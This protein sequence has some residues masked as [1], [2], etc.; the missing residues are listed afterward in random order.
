M[1]RAGGEAAASTSCRESH[2]EGGR[3]GRS[4]PARPCWQIPLD[5]QI[6]QHPPPYCARH[7]HAHA[8]PPQAQAQKVLSIFFRTLS[9]CYRACTT[10]SVSVVPSGPATR[11]VLVGGGPSGQ[12]SSAIAGRYP[13]DQAKI[14]SVSRCRMLSAQMLRC[15]EIVRTCVRACCS[16]WVATVYQLKWA[17]YNSTARTYPRPTIRIFNLRSSSGVR[18]G[19]PSPFSGLWWGH[20]EEEGGGL[21]EEEEEDANGGG[22]LAGRGAPEKKRWDA[23]EEPTTSPS[24]HSPTGATSSSPTRLHVKDDND[25]GANQTAPSRPC[26]APTVRTASPETVCQW[27]VWG[28]KDGREIG[29]FRSQIPPGNGARACVSFHLFL[30]SKFC[31]QERRKKERKY[32]VRSKYP[33]PAD[34]HRLVWTPGSAGTPHPPPHPGTRTPSCWPAGSGMDIGSGGRGETYLHTP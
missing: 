34:D 25:G 6:P 5:M 33:Q 12:N 15:C 13:A 3:P 29:A 23:S 31:W 18:R 7:A 21:E 2:K 26:D 16:G 19:G 10:S 17:L 11:R 9:S 14:K 24:S 1:A 8:M 32:S 30:W 27:D 20:K 22:W 28:R 4:S